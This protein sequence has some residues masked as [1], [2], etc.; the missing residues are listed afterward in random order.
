M[1]ERYR[2]RISEMKLEGINDG[3]SNVIRDH[4]R[5]QLGM[6]EVTVRAGKVYEFEI[7]SDDIQKDRE[8]FI[9]SWVEKFGGVNMLYEY[10]ASVRKLSTR[11]KTY[12]KK[13]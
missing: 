3:E 2:V 1:G 6:P 4:T 5:E 10:D 9:T 7:E 13:T 11:R 8:L 12:K